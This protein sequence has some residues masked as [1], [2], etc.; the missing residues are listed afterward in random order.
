MPDQNTGRIN[1]HHLRPSLAKMASDQKFFKD[2]HAI[3]IG[4]GANVVGDLDPIYDCTI[5]DADWLQ[6][7]LIDPK[8]CAYPPTQ[9]TTLTG[10][11]ATKDGIMAAM[12]AMARATNDESTVIIFFSGH[13][14][15]DDKGMT[16]L[17]PFGYTEE[18]N[19][20]KDA[21]DSKCL[22][23]LLA[24]FDVRKLVLIINCCH[25]AGVDFR[26]TPAK[27]ILSTKPGTELGLRNLPL[28]ET[29]INRLKAGTG[30]VVMLSSLAD[31][32]SF[33]GFLKEN[34][35]RRRYSAFTIG[36]GSALS[37]VGKQSNGYVYVTDIA[38]QCRK[39]VE[40]K[41]GNKQHPCF[42]IYCEDFPIAYYHGSRVN[43]QSVLGEN[44]TC[45]ESS[46][47][48]DGDGDITIEEILRRSLPQSY[49]YE[50]FTING[51]VNVFAGAIHNSGANPNWGVIHR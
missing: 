14:G 40:A 32:P 44:F 19:P 5:N 2:G 42:K 11:N 36:V 7:I 4:T 51:A 9:V 21:I 12:E 27:P 46:D 45:E 37:G 10:K 26:F 13:G 35:S 28:T 41:T 43:F 8:R 18:Q 49:R 16:F 29:Q 1:T 47:S 38:S 3:L 39:F 23:T 15:Q 34:T 24:A 20:A 30:F 17:C 50:N 6:D 33:T 25:S 48:E 22:S 31:E